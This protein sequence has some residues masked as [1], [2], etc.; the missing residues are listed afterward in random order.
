MHSRYLEYIGDKIHR[1][2]G[3]DYSIGWDQN[4]SIH[5]TIY[6]TVQINGR[7]VKTGE[8]FRIESRQDVKTFFDV[9]VN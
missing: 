7:W 1:M 4:D 6:L 9:Y 8:W 5:M 3:G 2:I